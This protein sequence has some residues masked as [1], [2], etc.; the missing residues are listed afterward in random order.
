VE[1]DAPLESESAPPM[2]SELFLA[3]EDDSDDEY[4]D[5]EEK[6]TREEL[7][8][9]KLIE[10]AEE[11]A[12][13][14]SNDNMKRATSAMK[15]R[16]RKDSTLHLLQTLSTSVSSIER[17]IKQF[18]EAMDDYAVKTSGRHEPGNDDEKSAEDRLSLTVSKSD[19][20]RMRI[21]GQFNLGFI[22]ATR[23][24][25]LTDLANA[26]DELFIIDQHASDEKYNFERLQSQTIVQN[27]RLVHP[28]LLDLTAIEEEIILNHGAALEKNGFEISI[29][30]SG[31]SPVGQRCRLTSL[32]MSRE[33]TFSLSDL[34]ELLALLAEHPESTTNV[35]RPAKVRRMFAMRACRSSIMVG[36]TLTI[37]QMEKVVGHMGEL[38][39]PWNCPHGRP[40]MRHLFS[41]D[42]W[43][44]GW[45]EDAQDGDVNWADYVEKGRETGLLDAEE[46]GREVMDV[47]P[48]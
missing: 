21:I 9:A 4:M 2:P 42:G 13:R 6:K 47:D 10:L 35:P 41:L 15:S 8:V 17:R 19:F 44:E 14:P 32:P 38:D 27:Q 22:L 11:R 1:S 26:Q 31:D 45:T 25:T 48:V 43:T 37:K 23:T 24:S 18:S 20:G 36:K 16:I 40:T 39:K 12:A 28:K 29:D 33:V 5:E 34:E 46:A 3:S 30:T 7:R